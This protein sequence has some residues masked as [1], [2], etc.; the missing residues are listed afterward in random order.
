MVM[1]EALSVSVRPAPARL[2]GWLMAIVSPALLPFTVRVSE[3][4]LVALGLLTCALTVMRSSACSTTGPVASCASRAVT[5]RMSSPASVWIVSV[6]GS[7]SSWPAWPSGAPRSA[8]PSKRSAPRDDTST[9]PPSP[10]AAPPRTLAPPANC[11]RSVDHRTTRPPSPCAPASAASVAPACTATLR[12]GGSAS[13][14]PP[15]K[16][17]PTRTVPPAALPLASSRAVPASWICSPST[18]IAP[19][20][21]P[22]ASALAVT[23]PVTRVKPARPP[24]IT[25]WPS[26]SARPLARTVPARLSTVS[27]KPARAA[28]RSSALPASAWAEPSRSR[29]VARSS[30]RALKKIRPSPS[31]STCTAPTAAAP[32]RPASTLPPMLT[33]GPTRATVPAGAWISPSARNS[34]VPAWPPDSCQRPPPPSASAV[35]SAFSVVATRPPTSTREPAPKITP[36]GFDRNTRPSACSWPRISEGSAPVTRLNSTAAASG[37]RMC[38]RSPAAMEKLDQSSAARGVDCRISSWRAPSARTLALPAVN[39]A[40]SG[41]AQPAGAAA[42][43]RARQAAWLSACRRGWNGQHPRRWR[44][45]GRAVSVEPGQLRIQP[46]V[47]TCGV[48]SRLAG[49]GHGHAQARGKAAR[50]LP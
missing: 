24:S 25:T 48:G 32:S 18:V 26:R 6:A 3:P 36:R 49:G 16:S 11:V 33:R 29:R 45:N 34:P 42:S 47:A 37:W 21:V 44:R 39:T 27:A 28:A 46:R 7:S 41:R 35:V 40:P 38:T 1:V 31:T 15:W 8:R 4:A 30:L 23:A 10:P 43:V 13:A 22:A 12:A 2:I 14:W 5:V 17:P 20:C 19:P 9:S 50:A